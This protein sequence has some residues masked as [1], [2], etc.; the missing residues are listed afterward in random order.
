MVLA[1]A[2]R[3]V[4]AIVGGGIL[5]VLGFVA[6]TLLLAS[7]Q[8]PV[9]ERGRFTQGLLIL[10]AVLFFFG[11]LILLGVGIFNPLVALHEVRAKLADIDSL[12]R[13]AFHAQSEQAILSIL[14]QPKY[15]DPK[16][17][18]QHEHKTFSQ[19]GEDG[20]IAEV[21]RRIGTTNR[22]FVEFGAS[23]GFENNTVLLLRQG[24]SGCWI[25]GDPELVKTAGT[26]FRTEIVGG[27]LT[28]MQRFI[29]AENIEDLFHDG[30]VPEEFDI[31]SID[32]DRNDYYVWRAVTHYRP[33]VVVIE[34]NPIYP[35][36]MSWVVPYDPS[37]MWDSTTRT[38]A[39]LKALE[40]L[41]ANM[42]YALVGCNLTGVNAFF[43]RK[44][45]VG[46]QFATPYTA[47]NHYEPS[48]YFLHH[49]PPLHILNLD[50]RSNRRVP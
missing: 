39:S 21:F 14:S 15:R 31:L 1:T 34:Y 7:A 42:G 18:S 25:E 16:R 32:I 30:K 6:L 9:Q 48:R 10:E 17:I 12:S 36:T 5:L 44:E 46:D 47:E 24:W 38:G 4:L 13:A 3:S 50:D 33:R 43:V 45:L 41:G 28:L 20:I 26:H 40:E 23:D 19:N 29:T 49:E 37:A 35:P 11:G 8:R 27:K 2:F 22:Y